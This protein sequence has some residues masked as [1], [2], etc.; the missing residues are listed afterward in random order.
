MQ[1]V[2]ESVNKFLLTS[3][4]NRFSP[5]P[6]VQ[7]MDIIVTNLQKNQISDKNICSSFVLFLLLSG[8][9]TEPENT[10]PPQHQQQFLLSHHDY[11]P[12]FQTPTKTL[13][14]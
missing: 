3:V 12:V 6:F 1:T 13:M 8:S 7:R 10:S 4:T 11:V 9:K 14:T 5:H 2:L